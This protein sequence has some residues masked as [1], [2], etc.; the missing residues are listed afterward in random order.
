MVHFS[1]C[2]WSIK[3]KRYW[4]T[5]YKRPLGLWLTVSSLCNMTPFCR[6]VCVI[7]KQ[8]TRSDLQ[9]R[10]KKLVSFAKEDH[11]EKYHEVWTPGYNLPFT[12]LLVCWL[13]RYCSYEAVRVCESGNWFVA[14]QSARLIGLPSGVSSPDWIML[15]SVNGSEYWRDFPSYL[16][17]VV[18]ADMPATPWAGSVSSRMARSLLTGFFGGKYSGRKEEIICCGFMKWSHT[19]FYLFFIWPC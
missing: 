2:Q 12:H 17:M 10:V 9:T 3:R 7:T 18:G 8:L 6:W 5:R 11:A 15:L 4:K 19:K 13:I 1:F 14:S 16:V